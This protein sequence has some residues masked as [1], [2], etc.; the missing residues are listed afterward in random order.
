[1]SPEEDI[2]SIIKQYLSGSGIGKKLKRYRIF[3]HWPEIVGQ[4][5]S[6]KT[7]PEK[8]FKGILYISVASS[9][10]ANEMSLMSR[11]LVK[12]I[13]KFIGEDIVKELRFKI[14]E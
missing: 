10:W 1:M 2:S 9:A 5:I 14:Q 4:K 8:L 7:K 13:N 11:R 6:S 12:E 3:N